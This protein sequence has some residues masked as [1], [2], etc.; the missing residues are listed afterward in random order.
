MLH[1][2]S[3]ENSQNSQLEGSEISRMLASELVCKEH[4]DVM[5]QNLYPRHPQHRGK[6]NWLLDTELSCILTFTY[7]S[8][9]RSKKIIKSPMII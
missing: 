8:Y 4:T 3:K 5:G 2:L 1:F 9:E 7:T 6:V